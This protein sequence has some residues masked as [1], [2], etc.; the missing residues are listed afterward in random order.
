M[1]REGKL[2]EQIS[3]KPILSFPHSTSKSPCL[4]LA[5]QRGR[6]HIGLVA[7]LVAMPPQ[8]ELAAPAP[9][10]GDIDREHEKPE[11]DH[12]EAEHR[13]EAEQPARDEQDAEPDADRLRLRQVPMAVEE[14]DF[15]GHAGYRAEP[16][17]R[18]T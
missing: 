9:H 4:R 17:S 6:R 13:Q 10:D 5:R 15:V 14:A 16:R 12:P 8:G 3:L 18:R 11:R 1:S 2:H 7:L